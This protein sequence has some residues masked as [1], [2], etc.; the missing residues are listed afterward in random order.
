MVPIWFI[1]DYQKI[2]K[3][4]I[5][6]LSRLVI[7][8]LESELVIDCPNCAGDSVTDLSAGI[9]TAFSGSITVFSGTLYERVITTKPFKNR[10][11]ICK[12]IGKLTAPNEI[13]IPCHVQ[14]GPTSAGSI[15]PSVP[16]LV[17]QHAVR[18]K[19]DSK[20]YQLFLKAKYFIVDGIK[21]LPTVPSRNRGFGTLNGIV[22]V[23]ATTEEA[24]REIGHP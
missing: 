4:V 18:I 2:Q 23:V 22:E 16:G 12:G 10:C 24:S 8:G 7:I 21:V 13:N 6:D 3:Q 9:Y 20:Y 1:K 19:T 15:L 14:W 17:G 11:S 5:S